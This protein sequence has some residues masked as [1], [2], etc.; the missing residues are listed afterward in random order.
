MG[1]GEYSWGHGADELQ[2]FSDPQFSFNMKL[3]V[4][5]FSHTLRNK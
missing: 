1:G 3:K 4:K 5:N 2:Y